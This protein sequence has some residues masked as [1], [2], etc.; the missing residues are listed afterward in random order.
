MIDAGLKKRFAELRNWV[1]TVSE[2]EMDLWVSAHLAL[3][4]SAA[5]GM[6]PRIYLSAKQRRSLTAQK[7]DEIFGPIGEDRRALASLIH[8]QRQ[9]MP[10]YSQS[11]KRLSAW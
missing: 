6:P 1:E 4:Y 7:H 8:A 9:G 3:Q 5:Q 11:G 10:I 2:D